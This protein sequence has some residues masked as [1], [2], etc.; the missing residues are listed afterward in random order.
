[1]TDHRRKDMTSG[2]T[3]GSQNV[4]FQRKCGALQPLSPVLDLR[5]NLIPL[6]TGTTSKVPGLTV[7]N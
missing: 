4:T 6:S 2:I 7:A 1:M 3:K 5:Q